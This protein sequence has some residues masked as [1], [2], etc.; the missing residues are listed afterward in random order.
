MTGPRSGP[1]PPEHLGPA[2]LEGLHTL[3]LSGQTRQVLDAALTM[4]VTM[5]H[6]VIGNADGVSIT[7]PRDGRY[8]TVAASN[9]VVLAMDHDQYDTGEGPCLDAARHG[10]RFHIDALGEEVRWS[11]FVPRARARG[12]ESV[13][14]SPLFDTGKAHGALNI[15][16]RTVGAFAVHEKQ[17]A[18]A[19]ALQASVVVT[20]AQHALPSAQLSGQLVQALTSRTLIARA[21]G[22][23]MHR[24]DLDADGAW[25]ALIAISR[26]TSLPLRDVCA[27]LIGDGG[28]PRPDGGGPSGV[29]P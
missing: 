2:L 9:D 4:V 10:E 13:L 15:Y 22:W 5:C 17:W 23:V 16:A 20:A 27:E 6:A 11:Q 3:A 21:Q 1:T 26:S 8:N 19:F 24:D 12:I 25:A 18:D 7:L 14:S 29:D 28:D